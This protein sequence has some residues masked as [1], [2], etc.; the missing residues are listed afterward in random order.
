[1]EKH[2]WEKAWEEEKFKIITLKPSV[3]V[4]RYKDNF[5]QGDFVLDVGCGNGRN[6][7]YLAGLGCNVDC[8][9]VADTKFTESLNP[10]LKRKINF[11]KT[12]TIKYPYVTEKYKAVVVT[13][14]LQYLNENE[15]LDLFQKILISLKP[16]GFILMSF[17]TQGGIFERKEI[18]VP[19]YRYSIEKIEKILKDIFKKVTITKGS[20]QSQSVNYEG[21]IKS[22]DIYA[23]GSHA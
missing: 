7:I 9:D 21:K 16:C 1:M 20:A 17:N 23:G 4:E 14:V 5:L 10:E 12:D 8:F 13:R 2:S 15:L 6:A 19:K 18:D 22:Y 3:V 11:V